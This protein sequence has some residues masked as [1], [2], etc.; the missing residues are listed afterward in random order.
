MAPPNPSAPVR[1]R[2]TKNAVINYYEP[3]AKLGWRGE[4]LGFEG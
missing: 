3:I 1:Q 2:K 4:L